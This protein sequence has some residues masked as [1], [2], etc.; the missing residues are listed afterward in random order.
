MTDVM[1]VAQLYFNEVYKLHDLP[2]LIVSDRDTHFLGHFWHC[3]WKLANT[4]LD[5]SPAYH[6]QTDGQTE[7]VN[8]SLGNLW[9]SL[10]EDHVKMWDKKL[11]QAEFACNHS[12]NRSTGLCP[13]EIVYGIILRALLDLDPILDLKQVY[14]EALEFIEKLQQIH[15]T[16]QQKLLETTAKYKDKAHKKRRCVEFHEGD[17]VYTVLTKDR[18]PVG[19]YNKLAAQRL[20]HWRL[21]KKL[22]PALTV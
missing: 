15:K 21:S 12:I 4:K 10:M 8:R 6:P 2:K 5:F 22:I 13:F 14:D 3:L 20:V 1:Q 11:S 7:V 19:E 16:T 18:F 9:R 17:L